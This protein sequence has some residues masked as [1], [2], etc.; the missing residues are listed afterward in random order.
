MK[1]VNE[2]I[3]I[4]HLEKCKDTIIGDSI[5]K[6]IF[7]SERKKLSVGME[8]IMN[9][10]IIFLVNQKAVYIHILHIL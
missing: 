3:S 1:I 7:G 4:L 2:M 6:G 5:L 10:S 8:M 9:R